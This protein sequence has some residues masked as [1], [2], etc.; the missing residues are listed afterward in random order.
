MKTFDGTYLK[1]YYCFAYILSAAC[2]ICMTLLGIFA[3]TKDTRS[4]GIIVLLALSLVLAVLAIISWVALYRE[5][6]RYH[7]RVFPFEVKALIDS[8]D[9]L[10]RNRGA[11][12]QEKNNLL[13]ENTMLKNK[14]KEWLGESCG[15][16]YEKVKTE[17]IEEFVKKIDEVNDTIIKDC[18]KT[19]I[20]WK[21]NLIHNMSSI[22]KLDG[23]EP[24]LEVT[25]ETEVNQDPN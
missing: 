3:F 21:D 11:L 20:A 4:Y 18:N 9:E 25:T 16:E 8:I 1:T 24:Q 2:V 17:L 7:E 14:L 15:E 6:G 13:N 5:K 23:I 22:M 10:Q 12:E 19:R